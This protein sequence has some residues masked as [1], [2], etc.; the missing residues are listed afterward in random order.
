MT[1][2]L[3]QVISPRMRHSA[4]INENMLA[5]KS[6]FVTLNDLWFLNY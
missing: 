5:K 4:I 6:V 3:E 1:I 2:M